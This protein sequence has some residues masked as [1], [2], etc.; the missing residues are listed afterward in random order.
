MIYKITVNNW[1]RYNATI[2]PG[3][4]KTMISNNFCTDAK[5]REVPVSVRWM[6]LGI[7]LACGD[8][9][10]DTVEV[11]DKQLRVLLESSWSIGRAL[12]SLQS[13]QVLSY[14]EIAV[15]TNRIEKKRREEKVREEKISATEPKTQKESP[16][17]P[18]IKDLVL[19]SLT[20]ES[21]PEKLKNLWNDHCG[22]L[23]KIKALGK[24]RIKNC[25]SRWKE[26]PDE[27]YWLSVI[28]KI[29]AS[30]FCNG[31][32]GWVANFDWFMNAK[33]HLKVIEGNYDNRDKKGYYMT[34]GMKVAHNAKMIDKEIKEMFGGSVAKNVEPI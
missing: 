26:N 12:S 5:L 24:D 23:P 27:N 30:D 2:K 9:G 4:K 17:D 3:H 13:L 19:I 25:T 22:S 21:P 8:V 31:E 16:P 7:V 18:P 34:Q 28:K 11:S 6:F 10:G 14:E 20:T 32:G 1:K 15:F 29:V 33:T